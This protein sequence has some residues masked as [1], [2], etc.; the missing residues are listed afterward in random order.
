MHKTL[1]RT[2][3]VWLFIPLI[4]LL[5]I[6]GM[7]E[8]RFPVQAATPAEEL[9]RFGFFDHSGHRLLSLG[10]TTAVFDWIDPQ[11][12]FATNQRRTANY[13][14][15]QQKAP[16]SSNRHTAGNFDRLAGH[17]LTV[18]GMGPANHSALL[19]GAA[20]FNDRHLPELA[21]IDG[22]TASA[23][24]QR[25]EL[26]RQRPLQQNW[27]LLQTNTGIRLQLLLFQPIGDQML[28]S[29]ALILP[30]R[31]IWR[32]FP[33]SYNPTSTWRVDDGGRIEPKQFRILY[34]GQKQQQWE[35]AYEFIGAEGILLEFVREKGE[36]FETV[37]RTSRY[38]SPL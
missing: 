3:G 29:L 19:V 6:F 30:D 15:L 1:S 24:R 8:L 31:V 38:T 12:V 13:D 25:I 34:L 17:R 37:S 21:E 9:I 36:G 14:S 18:N 7:S 35:L 27:P 26:L 11:V 33:A 28:A 20:F 10:P 16:G 5:I 4:S 2:A 23:D 22:E 32:D